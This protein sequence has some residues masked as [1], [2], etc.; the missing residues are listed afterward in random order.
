MAPLIDTDTARAL[1]NTAIDDDSLETIITREETEMIRVFGPH[2]DGVATVAETVTGHHRYNLLLS[3]AIASVTSIVEYLFVGDTPQTLLAADYFVWGAQ[4]R[5]TR[6]PQGTSW[7]EYVTVTYA[8]TNDQAL[9]QA[10]LIDLVRLVLTRRSA[11]SW[12]EERHADTVGKTDSMTAPANWEQERQ[13]IL[14]RLA[15]IGV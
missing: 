9:R 2:G 15:F 1:I 14:Q 11:R 12:M 7:G 13:S 3:R 4:G 5:I 6:L 8:P 10:V